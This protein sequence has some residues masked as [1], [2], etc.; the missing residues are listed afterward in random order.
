LS[1]YIYVHT[2]MLIIFML[3]LKKHF[4][5]TITHASSTIY[6]NCNYR[7]WVGDFVLQLSAIGAAKDSFF[8]VW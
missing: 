3:I 1:H 8:S 4:A 6:W 2:E 7:V 5:S